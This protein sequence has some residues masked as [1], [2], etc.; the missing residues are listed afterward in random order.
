MSKGRVIYIKFRFLLLSTLILTIGFVFTSC[1]NSSK[2]KRTIL[3]ELKINEPVNTDFSKFSGIE[4]YTFKTSNQ[5]TFNCE[6]KMRNGKTSITLVDEKGN[7]YL[8]IN[9]STQKSVV[10]NPSDETTY[11]VDLKYDNGIGSYSICIEN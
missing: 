5:V 3:G 7:E 11:F 10:L 6:L 2:P 1:A 8:S 4:S 9:S